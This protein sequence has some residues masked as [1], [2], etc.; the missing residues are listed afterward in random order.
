[1]NFF[2]R[3]KE[4]EILRREEE[5]SASSARF[6]IVM[7]R[8]RIG[9]TSLIRRNFQGRQCLYILAKKRGGSYLLQFYTKTDTE[10]TWYIRLWLG[11]FYA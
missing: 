9:K 6:T 3:E 8:R 1:M 4:L 7:G 5:L 10:G 2:G 11:T